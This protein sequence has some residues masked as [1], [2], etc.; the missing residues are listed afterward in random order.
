MLREDLPST[1]DTF[2]L[3]ITFYTAVKGGSFAVRDTSGSSIDGNLPS[4]L[5][6]VRVFVALTII[7]VEVCLSINS[8]SSKEGGDSCVVA[9]HT[10]D[11]DDNLGELI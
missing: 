2:R 10:R 11:R 9:T 1:V 6:D 3:N 5:R 8:R 7:L 4:K